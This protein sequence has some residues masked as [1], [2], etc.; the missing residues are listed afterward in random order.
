MNPQALSDENLYKKCQQYGEQTRVWRQKFAGLLPE[1]YRRKLHEKKGFS[2][3]FEFAKKLA[4]MSEEQVRRVLNLEKKFAEM[5]ILKS[6]LINAEVSMNKLAKVASIATAENQDALAN[7]INLLPCRALETLVR[8]EKFAKSVHVNTHLQQNIESANGE[9]YV[10][11]E[12]LGS[13]QNSTSVGDL[14]LSSEVKQKL[15][16]LRQKGIDINAFI[17]QAIADREQKIAQEKERIAANTP[18][19]TS[20]YIPVE[21]RTLLKKE[22][23]EKCSINGCQ[24]ESG[25]IHHT[26]R[27]SLSQNNNPKYLA[28]LC[29]EHHQIA[30]SI[31]VKFH[32]V[33]ANVRV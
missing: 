8:D 16:D 24:K 22:F 25:V 27:F 6:M 14:D 29:R 11:V 3:I 1:V 19:T 17:L 28:P 13:V 9:D 7:Q 5:P 30:H 21:T 23:G 18:T 12:K 33:V 4:G 2:S 15:L 10:R 20:R 31:D 26:Q 32:E